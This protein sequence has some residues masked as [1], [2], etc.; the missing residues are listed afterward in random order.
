LITTSFHTVKENSFKS[1]N[2]EIFNGV[3]GDDLVILHIEAHGSEEKGLFF[4]SRII[5]EWINSIV[6][7]F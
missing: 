7:V 2:Q 5:L 3:S 1:S 4:S 6:V